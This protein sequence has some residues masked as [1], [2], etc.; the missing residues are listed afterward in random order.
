MITI[1][2][3]PVLRK[4]PTARGS[5]LT[6]TEEAMVDGPRPRGFSVEG[7]IS[8]VK[9]LLNATEKGSEWIG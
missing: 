5:G 6:G 8:R 9:N 3:A 7:E 2:S 1:P 4:L